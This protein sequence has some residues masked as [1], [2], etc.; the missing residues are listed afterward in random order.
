[1]L[2]GGGLGISGFLCLR[3][4][5]GGMFLLGSLR[6]LGLAMLFG[7]D[8]F[9]FFFLLGLGDGFDAGVV[10]GVLL[11]SFRALLFGSDLFFGSSFFFRESGF[12][13][14]GAFGGEAFFFFDLLGFF[15]RAFFSFGAGAF[16]GFGLRLFPGLLGGF[17]FGGGFLGIDGGV[18]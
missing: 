14:L 3:S 17:G 9:L 13:G 15:G 1:V 5:F 11:F 4:L 2:F 18:G 12:F 16:F 10:L 8:S 7:F 6:G